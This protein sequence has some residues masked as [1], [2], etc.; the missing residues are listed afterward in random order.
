M[1]TSHWYVALGLLAMAAVS[2]K[3]EVIKG[4]I[5]VTGAEMD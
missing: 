2:A 1:H 4:V 5:S 3:A